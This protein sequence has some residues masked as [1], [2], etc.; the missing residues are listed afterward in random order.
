MATWKKVVIENSAGTIAQ[1]SAGLVDADYGDI[2][3]ASN[4]FTIDDNAVD[5]SAL[6]VNGDGSSGQVLQSNGN[7]SFAWTSNVTSV[8]LNDIT[9]VEESSE[10]NLDVLSYDGTNSRWENKTI[11]NAGLAAKVHNHDSA[12]FPLAGSATQ[13]ISV[14]DLTLGGNDI[15]SSGGTV[16]VTTSGANVTIA[17]D[18][19]VG[20][21]DIKASDGTTAITL[22]DT[23]GN[24]TIAGDLTVTGTNITTTTETVL[25]NDNLMVLNADKAND[26]DVD[27]GIMVERGTSGDNMSILWDEGDDKWVFSSNDGQNHTSPTYKADVTQTFIGTGT[28]SGS[29]T[30]VPVWHFLTDGTDMFLRTA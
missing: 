26:G 19:T 6:N 30:K 28:P 8:A 16:A 11:S 12:Y 2:T 7:G 18:V 20:G 13:D 23:T 25:I 9:D 5:A 3:V 14:Q 10:A 22:A 29:T 1:K 27:A 17:G 4:A 24:V 15:K 21:N